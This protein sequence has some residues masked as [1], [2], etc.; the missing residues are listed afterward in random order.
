LAGKHQR[1]TQGIGGSFLYLRSRIIQLAAV[2]RFLDLLTT[3]HS[4][5]QQSTARRSIDPRANH[6]SSKV[7]SNLFG[8]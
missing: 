3:S 4:G 2:G 7:L 6:L 1:L 5:A 8:I